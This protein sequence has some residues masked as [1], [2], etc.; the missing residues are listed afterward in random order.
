MPNDLNA[1]MVCTRTELSEANLEISID[2][3]YYVIRDGM[4]PG[5]IQYRRI[6]AESPFVAGRVPVHIVPDTIT[7]MP[8]IRV[9]G[10]SLSDLA[11]KVVDLTNAF[12][13]FQYTLSFA[14][15]GEFAAEYRCEAADYT[16]GNGGQFEDL[17]LRS[18]LQDVQFDV[19]AVLLTD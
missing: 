7:L 3:G 13:Q 8:Y 5:A 4:G 19:P 11:D 10:S 17:K 15:E 1:S 14:I 18:F 12:T 6:T 2:N 16:V 9:R